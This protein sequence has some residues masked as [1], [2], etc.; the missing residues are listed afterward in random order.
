MHLSEA[1]RVMATQARHDSLLLGWSHSSFLTLF[2][3]PGTKTLWSSEN[4]V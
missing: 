2:S 3:R 1:R 4:I